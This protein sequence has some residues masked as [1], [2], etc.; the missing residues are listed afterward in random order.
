MDFEAPSQERHKNTM[1]YGAVLLSLAAHLGVYATLKFAQH[2][3]SEPPPL[4]AATVKVELRKALIKP[5]LTPENDESPSPVTK[6][7]EKTLAQPVI[8]EAK[9]QQDLP[10][11]TPKT[12]FPEVSRDATV[13]DP[14]LRKKLQEAQNA[15]NFNRYRQPRMTTFTNISGRL[16]LKQGRYCS[17]FQEGIDETDLGLWTLPYKCDSRP[18]ESQRIKDALSNALREYREGPNSR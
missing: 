12:Q 5:S 14:R 13:F 8:P 4:T 16:V 18:D 1:L 6:V 17:A 2:R 11:A 15:P 3:D 10:L 9:P 7:P